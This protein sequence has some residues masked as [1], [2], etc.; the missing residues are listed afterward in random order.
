MIG[1]MLHIQR[2]SA[3]VVAHEHD[4]L[5]PRLALLA[6]DSQ[7]EACLLFGEQLSTWTPSA[8]SR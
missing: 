2:A 5:T 8:C 4:M 3:T 7:E 6:C 1:I